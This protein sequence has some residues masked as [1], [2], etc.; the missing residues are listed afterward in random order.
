MHETMLVV[1]SGSCVAGDQITIASR[2]TKRHTPTAFGD[3]TILPNGDTKVHSQKK[4]FLN[5]QAGGALSWRGELELYI[6]P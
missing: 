3:E 4:K 6:H 1:R 2:N 5:R